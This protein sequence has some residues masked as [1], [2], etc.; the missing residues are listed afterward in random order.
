MFAKIGTAE[1]ATDPMPPSVADTFVMLKDRERVARPAQA[2]EPSSSRSSKPRP[3]RVPGNNYEFTQPIQMRFN[4]LISGVR[5]DVAVKVYGDDLDTLLALG[6]EIEA[7]L[8][9]VP[10]GADVGVEQIT[11]LPMLT[12]EPTAHG[13]GPLRAQR[14]RRAGASLQRP[15]AGWP[16]AR[17]SRATG[18]SNRRAAARAAAQRSRDARARCP[19]RCAD[20]RGGYVPLRE[21]RRQSSIV[22]RAEPDQPRERQAARRGHRQRARPRPG[23]VRRRGARPH[24]ARSSCRPATGSSWAARSSS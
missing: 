20:G 4:E 3:R 24:R 6:G 21:R 1:V 10:G 11:G 14:R 2:E 19:C 23:L 5:A 18:A 8:A 17:C 16:W 13:A 9:G 22:E 12:V 15:S 7:M